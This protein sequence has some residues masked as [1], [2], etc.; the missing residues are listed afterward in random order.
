MDLLSYVREL[1]L[2]YNF[3]VTGGQKEMEEVEKQYLRAEH[4]DLRLAH[5]KSLILRMLLQSVS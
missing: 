5:R 2:M 3:G 1:C 4:S